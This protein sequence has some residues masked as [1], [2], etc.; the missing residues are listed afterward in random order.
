MLPAKIFY[1]YAHEDLDYKNDLS[2][3][4]GALKNNNK[5]EEWYDREIKPGVDYNVEISKRLEDADIVIFLITENFLNSK[6]CWGI[7]TTK[8]FEL[9]NKKAL[10]I[11]P[12]L[13]KPCMFEESRFSQLQLIPRDAKPISISASVPSAYNDVANEIKKVVN[14]LA[15]KQNN[16]PALYASSYKYPSSLDFIKQQVSTYSGLYE[17]TRQ[18]M[19]ASN[20]RTQK[21]QV[22]FDKMKCIANSTYPFLDEF[23]QSALPGERLAGISILH[24]F[25]NEKYFDFLAHVI[26]T[27][28]PFVAYQATLAI[29]FAVNNVAPNS[30]SSLSKAINLSKEN[31]LKASV[32]IHSDRYRVL[33]DAENELNNNINFFR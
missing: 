11:V 14:A 24:L 3:Y 4:L 32:S 29:K 13:V 15:E 17:R 30:Y 2:I 21:M 8:A 16:K 12:V 26:K 18:F 10:E 9:Q 22:I 25:A 23:I 20:E 19:K 7:E 27:D 6:Y 28:K 5:I 33:Q 31:L 1:S